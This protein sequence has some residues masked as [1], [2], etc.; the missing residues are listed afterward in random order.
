[1]GGGGGYSNLRIDQ[2]YALCVLLA[3]F[4]FLS[5]YGKAS[6]MPAFSMAAL[7]FLFMWWAKSRFSV[8]RMLNCICVGI[9]FIPAGLWMFYISTNTVYATSELAFQLTQFMRPFHVALNLIFP[10]AVL[11]ICRRRLKD[12]LFLSVAW[13]AYLSALV[14]GIFIVEPAREGSGNLMWAILYATVVL[15]L[16]SLME[17]FKFCYKHRKGGFFRWEKRLVY[18]TLVLAAVHFFSGIWY[19]TDIY[20]GRGWFWF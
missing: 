2:F 15:F 18:V 13:L 12:N 1:G 3:V 6:W 8:K 7:I 14:Q 10:V 4:L 9:A 17:F 5:V 11:I 16:V 19:A 20:F